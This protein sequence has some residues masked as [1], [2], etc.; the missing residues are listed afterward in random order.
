[1]PEE[2][3]ELDILSAPSSPERLSYVLHLF[4]HEVCKVNGGKY[5]PSSIR[6]L[7]SGIGRE[8][9]D[10]KVPFNIL[11]G[12]DHRFQD[13]NR[14]LGTINSQLNCDGVRVSVKKAE[15]I[16]K[17]VEQLCSDKGTLGISSPTVLQHTIFFYLG[18]HVVLR[19]VQ[20]QH[21]LLVKQL[22][23]SNDYSVYNNSVYYEYTEFISKNNLHCFSDHCMKNK[24]VKAYAQPQS[25]HCLVLLLD[26]YLPLLPEDT[27]LVYM[28]PLQKFP[29]TELAPAYAKQRVGVNTLK[30]FLQMITSGAGLS[31]YTNHSLHATAVSRMYN[32]GVPEKIIAERSG[33]RS[34]V[35]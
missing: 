11:D 32:T 33:H 24:V 21:D 17:E 34:L 2:Q 29:C 8:L 15:V 13:L 9:A 19:G 7:L 30:R 28:H 35:L 3:I 5:P 6:S 10:N 25:S 18:L 1:M 22:R 27:L 4:A 26:K 12:N 14:T 31:G 16:T 20:E 23:V